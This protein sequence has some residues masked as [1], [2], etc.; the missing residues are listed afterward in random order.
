MA[1]QR[2]KISLNN[3]RFPLVS[4]WA[5]RAVMIPSM[6]TAVRAPRQFQGAEENIDFD[7]PQILYG[8]NFVPVAAGVK[9]V[10]YNQIIVP[11]LF[12]DFDQIFP[13][14]DENENT[15]LFSPG[16]GKNYVFEESVHVWTQDPLVSRWANEVPPVYL[17]SNSP[18]TPSTSQVTRA[19]VE[20][21]TFIAYKR[22][23]V[24]PVNGGTGTMTGSLY[25][26]DPVAKALDRVNPLDPGDIIT[27]LDIDI[28]KIDGVSSSNGYLLIWSG[29]EVHWA[30]FNGSRFDFQPYAN[31]E[32][33]GAG[34]Q[35]PEDLEGP[36]TA[37]VPVSG[38]FIIF[39]TKNAVAAYYN[40]NNFASPWIFKR[41]SNAG[42]VENYE[43]AGLEGGTGS[44][45]CYTTGGLQR[46][47]LNNAESVAPDV[48]D[49]LGGRYIEKFNTGTLQFYDGAFTTEYFVKV[50][51]CGQRFLVISYGTYPGLFSYAL[52]Y[53]TALQ[54]WG[55]LRIVHRD[56][57]SYSY[58]AQ[59]AKLTYSMLGDV[60]YDEMEVAYNDTTIEGGNLT[61]P[62]Q[63]IAF[64]MKTGEVKLGVLDYRPPEDTSEAFVII[65]RN[66][67]SRARFFELHHL[68]IEGLQP[69]AVVGTWASKDGRTLGAIEMGV[70]REQSGDYAEYGFDN[71][72][73]K[74]QTFYIKG[75]F[76][77]STIVVEG[78]PS[79]AY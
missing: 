48:T 20:G 56:C 23:T 52:I 43:Q 40:A 53:D 10:S 44:V 35:I 39:T 55:K 30:P 60:S 4:K 77:L 17:G 12:N 9:S 69:G 13:L 2:Y 50:T 21:K 18:L 45:Y 3:A 70:L 65:G 51:Y 74:N 26:W 59:D 49:F 32:V 34:Q 29:L 68:E 38:G 75:D 42:G 28:D 78:T 37:I 47:S 57:F 16:G 61:Y 73:G 5:P 11:T 7:I 46:I 36:I 76:A 27:N 72:T 64:L 33:T 1:N 22:M 79:D 31:G 41:I 24:S 58:G 19:Y 62:R 15:V 66:Q 25:Q 67:L 63:S 6:D 14:R 71:P 8:E 54:R